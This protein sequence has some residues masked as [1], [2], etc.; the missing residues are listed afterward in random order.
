MVLES[1][2]SAA[3]KDA[4]DILRDG[5]TEPTLGGLVLGI[6][7]WSKEITSFWNRNNTQT[8]ELKV[9][10]CG[11]H[12]NKRSLNAKRMKITSYKSNYLWI[13]LY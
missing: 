5:R 12:W 10:M 8:A 2:I 9:K 4:W 6:V 13:F 1:I 7:F 3:P 11:I